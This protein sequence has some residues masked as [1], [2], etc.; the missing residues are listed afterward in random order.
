MRNGI[1]GVVIGLVVGVV[2]GATVV[3][4]R[5]APDLRSGLLTAVAPKARPPPIVSAPLAR[6]PRVRWKMASA[7]AA[8]LPQLGTL[9]KRVDDEIWRVSGGDMEMK[10][11]A[12]GTLVPEFEMF[13]AVASGAIDA[14]FS[15]P[16]RWGDRIPALRLFGAVPFGP[17]AGE[18]LAWIY[19]GGGRELFEEIHRRSGIHSLFCGVIAPEASGWFRKEIRTLDDLKGLKMAFHGLGAKVMTKLGVEVLPLTGGNV[20]LALERGAIDATEFSMP[21]VDLQLGFHEMAKHYYFPGWHQPATLFDLM[22]N[23]DRWKALSTTQQARLEAVCGDNIRYGLA[24]GEALQFAALKTLHGK[25]VQ[26]H[27]WP[28][29]ILE[30]MERAWQEVAAEEAAAD[31]DFKRVWESLAAFRRDYGIWKELG[32][33]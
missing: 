28:Q 18:Y 30:A 33:L 24:E 10:F 19:F 4:P 20:F 13:D 17:A 25:G 8:V 15:S 12:P 7:Y 27:R 29:T 3:A 11:F 22:I 16:A 32:Y 26:L 6:S 23:L 21:A 9:A 14:A 5:L 31:P 2:V 1:I